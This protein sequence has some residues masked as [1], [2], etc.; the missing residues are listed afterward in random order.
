MPCRSFRH[1]CCG[2]SALSERRRS[3]ADRKGASPRQCGTRARAH[4]AGRRRPSARTYRRCG[5]IRAPASIA[6]RIRGRSMP[7]R[8]PQGPAAAPVG[9][10]M[11]HGP[12]GSALPRGGGSCPCGA[13][14]AWS[15]ALIRRPAPLPRRGRI[16][17]ARIAAAGEFHQRFGAAVDRRMRREN[18]G[19]SLAR[20]VD[21]HF[22]HRRGRAR[23][24]AAALDLAQGRDHRV[25]IFGQFH[26]AGIGEKFARARQREADHDREQPGERDQ[27]DRENDRRRRRRPCVSLR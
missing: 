20:I 4:D 26:R 10:G 21:A 13:C 5:A 7:C 3:R 9:S 8:A 27:R 22:H 11:F 6:H 16:E 14:A 23:Q 15:S 17:R 19:K 18:I 24:F 25:G 12:A 1:W 2:R